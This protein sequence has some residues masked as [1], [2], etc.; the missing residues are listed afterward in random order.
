MLN[1]NNSMFSVIIPYYK[2]REYIE[3]CIDHILAQTFKSYEII[4]VDD[5]SNDGF[6]DF[7]NNKYG[8][9]VKVFVQENQG[10]SAAR[11]SG[12]AIASMEY[13]AFLDADDYWAPNYLA[14]LAKVIAENVDVKIIG[15]NYTRQKSDLEKNLVIPDYFLIQNYFRTA[16]HKPYFFTSATV[17][18]KAFFQTEKGFN[19]SLKSGEDID[20]WFRAVISGGNCFFIKNKLVY[21]SDED[22]NQATVT[23]KEFRTRFIA[24]INDLYLKN[25]HLYPREFYIFLSKYIYTSIY[26]IYYERQYHNHCKSLLKSLN[27]RFLLAE[28]YYLLPYDIWSRVFINVWIRKFV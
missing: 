9:K 24:N 27:D 3:R 19:T 2:K 18:K 25:S 13:V 17:I 12:I 4:V 15:T 6:S 10:V 23:P 7:C 11:N 26:I 1:G 5:G 14:S 28:L 21:Y 8:N 16:L 22:E 20:V